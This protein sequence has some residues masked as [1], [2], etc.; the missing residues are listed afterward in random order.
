MLTAKRTLNVYV[1]S[2]S[3]VVCVCVCMGRGTSQTDTLVHG[4]KTFLE[5]IL[6]KMIQAM[7]WIIIHTRTHAPIDLAFR[8]LHF[9]FFQKKNMIYIRRKKNISEALF[10]QSSCVID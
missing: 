2:V 4:G 9:F 5:T 10:A 1:W 3:R 8:D 7:A 6:L